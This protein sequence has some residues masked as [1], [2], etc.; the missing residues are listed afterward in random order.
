LP[1]QIVAPTAVQ[2]ALLLHGVAAAL[3]QVSH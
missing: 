3:L 2:S 1:P